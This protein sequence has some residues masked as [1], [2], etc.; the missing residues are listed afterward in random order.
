MPCSDVRYN[1][2]PLV[3]RGLNLRM[4]MN[5]TMTRMCI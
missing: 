4:M 5:E 2:T 1:K 3:K